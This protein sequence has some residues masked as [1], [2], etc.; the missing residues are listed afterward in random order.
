MEPG[1]DVPT[2]TLPLSNTSNS[3]VEALLATMKAAVAPV[4]GPQTVS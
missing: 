2:P 4:S 3:E 1:E